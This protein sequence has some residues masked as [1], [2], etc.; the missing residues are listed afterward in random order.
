[1]FPDSYS[2][3]VGVQLNPGL[4]LQATVRNLTNRSTY[5]A[6]DLG[7]LLVPGL[8]SRGREIH[9]TLRWER[10]NSDS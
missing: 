5:Q 3:S 8:P 7:P 6:P 2:T 4:R 10:S 9:L 1:M